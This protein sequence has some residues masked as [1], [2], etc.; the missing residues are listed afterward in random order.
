LRDGKPLTE[1]S[2]NSITEKTAKCFMISV[3]IKTK[4]GNNYS[5]L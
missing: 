2:V 3:T 1:L 5:D 4:P